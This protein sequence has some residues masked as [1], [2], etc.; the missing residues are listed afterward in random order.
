VCVCVCVCVCDAKADYNP[1]F[2]IFLF[3][4]L[5]SRKSTRA[6]ASTRF[7]CIVQQRT[8]PLFRDVEKNKYDKDD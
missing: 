1:S 8:Q 6:R 2:V 7:A 4:Q 3:A 5:Y